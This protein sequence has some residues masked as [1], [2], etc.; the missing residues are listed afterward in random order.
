MIEELP[1]PGKFYE[2]N[3]AQE[4]AGVLRPG[5]GPALRYWVEQKIT[6]WF[7]ARRA[8]GLTTSRVGANDR[9]FTPQLRSVD[10]RWSSTRSAARNETSP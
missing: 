10:I 5:H 4:L 1:I 2:V 7:R 6:C 9:W 3:E 8:R